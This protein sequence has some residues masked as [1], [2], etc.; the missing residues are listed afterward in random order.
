MRRNAFVSRS[1]LST[2]T[3]L[4]LRDA[5]RTNTSLTTLN[6]T[7]FGKAANELVKEETKLLLQRN[8]SLAGDKLP[9]LQQIDFP[10]HIIE[11]LSV[12]RTHV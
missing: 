6:Y 3:L 7:Q 12:Y 2:L 9:E 4:A 8:C 1:F 5:L 11:I 10:Q